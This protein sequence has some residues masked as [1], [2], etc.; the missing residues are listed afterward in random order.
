MILIVCNTVCKSCTGAGSNQCIRCK[1]SKKV[2]YL[3]SCLDEC[4]G[5]YYASDGVCYGM[6]DTGEVFG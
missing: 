4:P 5:H 2:M 3:G 6:D 1:S